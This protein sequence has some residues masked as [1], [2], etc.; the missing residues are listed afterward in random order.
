MSAALAGMPP[1]HS[2]RISCWP[3]FRGTVTVLPTLS[4]ATGT[5]STRTVCARAASG[6]LPF[7][8]KE[9]RR[10]VL[11]RLEVGRGSPTAAGKQGERDD[12]AAKPHEACICHM[13]PSSPMRSSLLW[14]SVS[15]CSDGRCGRGHGGLGIRDLPP[16][17]CHIKSGWKVRSPPPDPPIKS[18]GDVK[19]ADEGEARDDHPPLDCPACFQS[20]G[21]APCAAACAIRGHRQAEARCARGCRRAW[22][23][24]RRRRR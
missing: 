11:G 17:S 19:A 13:W 4:L 14:R 10:A 23:G 3:G 5:P 12:A 7:P 8:A 24:R 9:E 2:R 21:P 20:A 6:G 16:G 1:P 18:A 22:R 15:H